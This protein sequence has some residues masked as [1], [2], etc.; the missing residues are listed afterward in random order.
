MGNCLV[1]LIRARIFGIQIRY[2]TNREEYLNLNLQINSQLKRAGVLNTKGTKVIKSL[3]TLP[4]SEWKNW[5]KELIVIRDA[6]GNQ[7]DN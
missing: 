2:M 3:D 1:V 6:K 5:I 4:D 7:L